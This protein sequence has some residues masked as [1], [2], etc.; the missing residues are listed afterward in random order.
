MKTTLDFLYVNPG[1]TLSLRREINQNNTKVRDS[2]EW[3][4]S[5]SGPPAPAAPRPSPY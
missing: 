5:G 4:I 2:A 3:K 1:R